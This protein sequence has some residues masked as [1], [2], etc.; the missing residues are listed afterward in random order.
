M[1][2]SKRFRFPSSFLAGMMMETFDG[3]MASFSLFLGNGIFQKKK[4]P[5]SQQRRMKVSIREIKG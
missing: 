4:N 3:S 2:V 5:R 1:D